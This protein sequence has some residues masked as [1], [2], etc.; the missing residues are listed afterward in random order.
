MTAKPMVGEA[1]GTL[2]HWTTKHHDQNPTALPN[3]RVPCCLQ[4][5][6]VLSHC[7]VATKATARHMFTFFRFGVTNQ[8]EAVASMVQVVVLVVSLAS[9]H[10][11]AEVE[12][13]RAYCV[14]SF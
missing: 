10:T 13:L 11:V 2:L 9:S 1:R 8:R 6:C 3:A 14:P 4:L 5:L 12:E 7:V